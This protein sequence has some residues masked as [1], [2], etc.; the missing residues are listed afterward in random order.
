[1]K[2]LI[3]TLMV[4]ALVCAGALAE[5]VLNVNGSGT[6]YMTADRV[7][8]T[9]GVTMT[10][11]DVAQMQSEVNARLNTIC[12]ALAE[13]GLAESDIST[14][15][16]YIYPQYDYSENIQKLVGYS[17]SSSINVTT[18]DVDSIG[19][20]IDAAFAAGANTFDSIN[21]SATDTADAK[22]QALEMAVQ[23]AM[24]KAEVIAAA[25]GG[26]L[27][28]LKAVSEGEANLYSNAYAFEESLGGVR[29]YADKVEAAAGTSVHAAQ[30]SVTA[31]VQLTYELR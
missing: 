17:I 22:K 15:S 14:N 13:A 29:M 2:K 31:N 3:C 19:A 11:E 20:Y 1:M 25:A 24:E 27:G 4:L 23:S 9:M 28:E 18:D 12:A 30:I 5:G 6:V 10:G 16:I 7:S 8:A 21:F 26:V